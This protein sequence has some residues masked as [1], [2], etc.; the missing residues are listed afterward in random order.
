MLISDP[1]LSISEHAS[2]LFNAL[3]L[4]QLRGMACCLQQLRQA[5][6]PALSPCRW[7]E[8]YNFLVS[9]L[10]GSSLM[11]GKACD[12]GSPNFSSQLCNMPTSACWPS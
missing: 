10:M 5:S 4:L 8:P 11:Y 7:H 1:L 2:Q 12:E 9:S 6:H 3:K